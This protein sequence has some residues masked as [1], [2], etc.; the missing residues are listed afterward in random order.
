M[1]RTDALA[2]ISKKWPKLTTTKSGLMFEVLKQ[3]QGGFPSPTSQV[4]V[5]YTGTLLDGKVFDS[6]S[7]RGKPASFQVNRVIP[8]WTE[9]L[10]A[11]KRGE[12]VRLVIP[13]ELG[14]GA[15]GYPGV[16]PPNSFLVFEV[17]L[18]DF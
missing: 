4:S 5:N 9:A 18:I 16:I 14:Y 1:E 8:G 17:E 6:T 13:P 7:T 15:Q 2:Q 10:V 12:K 11:M 3:G